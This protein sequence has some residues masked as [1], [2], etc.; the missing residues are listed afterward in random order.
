MRSK[1]AD[2]NQQEQVIT[3]L[4]AKY[5]KVERAQV[6]SVGETVSAESTRSAVIAVLGACL[7]IL[8]YLTLAFRRAPHPFRYGVC[9][10]MK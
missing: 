2:P 3:A 9:A 8:I 6:Q 5:G 10:R 1:A 4:T 7:A